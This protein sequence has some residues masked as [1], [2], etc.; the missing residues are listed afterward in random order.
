MSAVQL[1]LASEAA[2]SVSRTDKIQDGP[3]T[4]Q[5]L[6]G[7]IQTNEAEETMLNQIPLRCSCWI[8]GDCNRQPEFVCQ[9]L[10][11]GLPQ[12]TAGIV[13]P[14]IV[15]LNQ[16]VILVGVR[17]LA[18]LHPPGANRRDG[19]FGRFMRDANHDIARVAGRVVDAIRQRDARRGAAKVGLEHIERPLP[20]GTPGVLEIAD[21]FAFLSVDRNN[22]FSSLLKGA[23]QTG[24]ISHLSIALWR[25]LGRQPLAVRSQRVVSGFQQA[26]HRGP[27]DS[28]P[29]LPQLLAQLADSLSRPFRARDWITGGGI[30]QQFVQDRQETRLFFS[31]R[32]RPAP[33]CR[34]CGPLSARRGCCNS[35]RPRTM[36]L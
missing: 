27:S 12:P 2:L 34:T 7:P 35:S 6:P 26:A 21:Q 24:D 23:P 16:Q 36:V 20:P 8:M 17:P 33:A 11:A 10:Q 29:L 4:D 1:R 19:K 25:R 22:G 18:H 30:L 28:Q 9:S 32:F 31:T 5:G 3:V 14:A 15:G 13:G